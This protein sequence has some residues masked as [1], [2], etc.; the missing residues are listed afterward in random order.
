MIAGTG[1]RR[2]LMDM[3]DKDWQDMKWENGVLTIKGEGNPHVGKD[4][5]IVT[6]M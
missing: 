3:K 6:L 2:I 4:P 1:K 5:Y